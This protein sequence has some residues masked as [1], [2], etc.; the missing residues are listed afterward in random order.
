M[1]VVVEY[2]RAGSALSEAKADQERRILL[3]PAVGC[4]PRAA[5]MSQE[6]CAHVFAIGIFR[7][8]VDVHRRIVFVDFRIEICTFDI[9][10]AQLRPLRRIGIEDRAVV[11]DSSNGKA[12]NG[13]QSLERRGG[14]EVRGTRSIMA[15]HLPRD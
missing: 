6:T 5:H 2:I 14:S 9:D 7:R 1:L 12:E 10:K 4:H 8:K 13:S 11:A 15:F 3:L